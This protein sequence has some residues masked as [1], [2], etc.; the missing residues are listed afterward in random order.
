L[1]LFWHKPLICLHPA[2]PT[3][4][5]LLLLVSKRPFQDVH[6]QQQ[7]RQHVCWHGA[8][9]LSLSVL[10]TGSRIHIGQ[11]LAR[12]RAQHP[13]C[14]TT[15]GKDYALI[16]LHDLAPAS[17]AGPALLPGLF[18]A[19]SRSH[20]LA[21]LR[22]AG[23]GGVLDMSPLLP[24]LNTS[25]SSSSGDSSSSSNSTGLKQLLSSPSSLGLYGR[26]RRVQPPPV[27]SLQAAK[28]QLHQQQQQQQQHEVVKTVVL[29]TAKL[30]PAPIHAAGGQEAGQADTAAAVADGRQQELQAGS[31]NIQQQQQQQQQPGRD[32]LLQR[33]AFSQ[34]LLQ[35]DGAAAAFQGGLQPP[36]LA[37]YRSGSVV[38][39]GLEE[40]EELVWLG[41]FV[42]PSV[43][44]TGE[45]P[46]LWLGG[47]FNCAPTLLAS[48]KLFTRQPRLAAVCVLLAPACRSMYVTVWGCVSAHSQAWS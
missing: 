35:Q 29:P 6:S 31:A 41:H 21:W 8:S 39:G 9:G 46:S 47:T 11:V 40:R 5:V 32:L 24:L 19:I 36:F 30:A 17:A 44:Y 43:R 22:R 28:E 26:P 20:V 15:A 12:V 14:R 34:Q 25:G 16:W 1:S 3:V 48:M 13:E 7:Y 18:P 45:D 27:V 42:P 23:L 37:V 2:A 10:H 33:M 38:F 4:A